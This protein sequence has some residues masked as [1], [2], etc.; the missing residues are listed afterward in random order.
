MFNSTVK[1]TNGYGE[2]RVPPIVIAASLGNN[3][4]TKILLEHQNISVNAADSNVQTALHAA[5]MINNLEIV[6]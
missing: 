6:Q 5:T 1:N 3:D 2:Y 4:I